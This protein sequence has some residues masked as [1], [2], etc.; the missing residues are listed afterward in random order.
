MNMV[1][2]L[3][4]NN[5]LERLN[6]RQKRGLQR[7]YEKAFTRLRKLTHKTNLPVTFDNH[8]VTSYGNFGLFETFKKAIDYAGLLKKHFTIKRHHN[9]RYTAAALADI[10]CGRNS[11][12]LKVGFVSQ[13]GELI[14]ADLYGG[15]TH[16][17]KGFLEFFKDTLSML[18]P[19][20]VVKGVRLDK[21]F[22]DEKNF[23]YFEDNC[24]EYVCKAKLSS[25]VY[26]LINYV[27]EQKS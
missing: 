1:S 13:T 8:T 18:G 11:Y 12:K 20:T 23:I 4:T 9:C 2:R 22:F 7:K 14:N 6:R 19:R 26:K 27:N 10:M 3:L 17:N 25:N 16:S 21:G 5:Q 15:T 24:I